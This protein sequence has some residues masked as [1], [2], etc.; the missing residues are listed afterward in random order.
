MSASRPLGRAWRGGEDLPRGGGLARVRERCKRQTP[1]RRPLPRRRAARGDRE[2]VARF[3]RG[4]SY[5]IRFAEV[6]IRDRVDRF[7]FGTRSSAALDSS[8]PWNGG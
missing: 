8:F 6:S 4:V 1:R 2:R 3:P 7:W 5:P